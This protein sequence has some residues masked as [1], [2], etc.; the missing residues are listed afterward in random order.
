MSKNQS[1]FVQDMDAYIAYQKASRRWSDTYES[2]LRV[3]D[4]YCF[5]LSPD[6]NVLTQEMVNGWCAKRDTETNN[7]CIARIKVVSSFVK[8]LRTRGKTEVE[9]PD[10]PQ[11][12]RNTYIPHAFTVSELKN[13]FHACDSIPPSPPSNCPAFSRKIAIPVFFRLLYSSGIR[14]NEARMLR[15]CDVDLID[16]ILNIQCSKGESQHY[17]VLH[18][19]MLDL[20]KKY[21]TAIR[22]VYPNREYFFASRK[23]SYYSHD[24]VNRHFREIWYKNNASYAVAYTLRHHYATENINK[25]VCDG[26]DFDS[27]LLYLSRSMG[28]STLES[29]KY[30]YSLVPAMANIIEKLS[31]Q[32]FNDIVPEVDYEEGQ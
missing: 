32:G 24:W 23:G 16:G 5:H 10:F 3:F 22:T 7:S 11:R 28:H 21:D 14:T 29:T 13:F 27:K 18:D 9:K 4:H 1:F 25:W 30:Y 15:V 31:S 2:N 17:V 20:M 26:F 19:S 8:Y 6:S 12:E